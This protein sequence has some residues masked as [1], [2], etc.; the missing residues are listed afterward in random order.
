[1]LRMHESWMMIT[2]RDCSACIILERVI[3]HP[4]M[5]VGCCHMKL[6]WDASVPI[7]A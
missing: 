1:M 2:S 5:G 6:Y 4:A 7:N 3:R